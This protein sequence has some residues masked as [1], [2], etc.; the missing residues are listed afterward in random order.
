MAACAHIC[1]YAPAYVHIYIYIYICAHTCVWAH[2]C[3][4]L[5][6]CTHIWV[7]ARIGF[8][9]RKRNLLC[10]TPQRMRN[11]HIAATGGLANFQLLKAGSGDDASTT[12]CDD[13]SRTASDCGDD[14]P[15][16]DDDNAQG[17]A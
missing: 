4:S 1:A 11:C 2:V 3:A 17:L 7:Y 13:A 8:V 16:T 12:D 15:S 5:H 14:A 10:R 9:I 6:I